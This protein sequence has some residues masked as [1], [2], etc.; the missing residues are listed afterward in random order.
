MISVNFMQM[1]RKLNQ[2]FY[3]RITDLEEQH[4]S[5]IDNNHDN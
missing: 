5:L 1:G 2:I 3:Y 4:E